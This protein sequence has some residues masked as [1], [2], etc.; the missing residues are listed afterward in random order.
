M[1]TTI[2]K[3]N[4]GFLTDEELIS[5]FCVRIHEY[6]SILETLHTCTTNAN[7]HTI[8]I[9][10]RGSGKTH[11]LLRIAAQV[12]R[13]ETLACFYP[14]IFAEES[15][16]VT[17]CGEF[18]LECL[19]RLA[20][21]APEAERDGLHLSYNDIRNT[22]ED[23]VLADRC[24]GSL[25]DF[26]D[27]QGQRLLLIAENL[28]MLFAE[29]ADPDAGWQ[30]RKLLQTEPRILLLGSATSRFAEIDHRDHALY[31]L[32]RVVTLLPLNTSEC[33]VLWRTVSGKLSAHNVIRP[34]EILTGGNP[35]LLSIIAH[36]GAGRSLRELM[37][38][39]LDLVDEHTE[40]FK[41]HLEILPPQERRIYLALARLWKPASAREVSGLARMNTNQGSA[42][43][44][45]LV[46]RGAVTEAG[47]TPRRRQYCLTERLYN[48][49]YLLRRGG[50]ADRMVKALIEFMVCLY[51]PSDLGD[52]LEET[53]KD[54][55]VSRDWYPNLAAQIADVLVD[56]AISLDK[57]GN[58]KEALAFCNQVINQLET[59][60]TFENKVQVAKA[61]MV[62]SMLL[63]RRGQ[64]A[65]AVACCD[66]L[67]RQF[68]MHLGPQFVALTGWALFVKGVALSMLA[69]RKQ[70]EPLEA[71]DTFNQS[72][73]LLDSTEG[74]LQVSLKAAILYE[75]GMVYMALGQYKA[76]LPIFDQVVKVSDRSD[77]PQLAP[78][79]T[80]ALIQKGIA[81]YF[82][83]GAVDEG[84]FSLLLDNLAKQ[85]GLP[86][87]FMFMMK[88]LVTKV[89]PAQALALI[90]ASPAVQMLL[91]LAT[92]LQQELGQKPRV[93]REVKE[94]AQDVRRVLNFVASS[95]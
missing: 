71:V 36:F 34:L 91:P 81:L 55:P 69:K 61:Y 63:V 7:T 74:P 42:L 48:I 62:K 37:D 15:Y 83:D 46:Q 52:I 82:A 16:E 95:D 5:S 80:D 21:Q 23:R 27:R 41:S 26:A 3:Y 10:P 12:R 86:P 49:Y 76:A 11:L 66:R 73:A 79:V 18:L 59:N 88:L 51:S 57:R 31:D 40:Y 72:L 35:R 89:S 19:E 45:R 6:E 33:E 53:S 2:K 9:G 87:G 22:T 25:L 65:A 56:H 84:D 17:T 30:L 78:T 20:Y 92:A 1:T 64:P 32:F 90:Q 38:N 47:G 14:I 68:G 29:M 54:T 60:A 58:I 93:S 39:L 94:V 43:L 77:E 75:K 67:V 28:N 50:A 8:V 24:L 4:P 13:D 70:R 85:E 44:K